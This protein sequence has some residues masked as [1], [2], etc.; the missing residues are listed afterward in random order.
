MEIHL[1]ALFMLGTFTRPSWLTGAGAVPLAG[2]WSLTTNALDV[3]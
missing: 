1:T 2:L 3:C